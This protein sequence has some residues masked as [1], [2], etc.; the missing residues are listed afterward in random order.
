LHPTP[1][2]GLVLDALPAKVLSA[3]TLT[4]GAVNVSQSD[5]E[6]AVKVASSNRDAP[7]T[8]LEL[9]LDRTFAPGIVVGGIR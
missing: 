1:T 6:L 4:G 3:R 5:E 7:V 2:D 8:V 9:T